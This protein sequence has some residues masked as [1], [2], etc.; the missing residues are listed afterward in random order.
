[1]DGNSAGLYAPKGSLTQ[2][3][4]QVLEQ[5]YFGFGLATSKTFED[6]EERGFGEWRFY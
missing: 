4:E 3:Y 5:S 6:Y 2:D 1:M